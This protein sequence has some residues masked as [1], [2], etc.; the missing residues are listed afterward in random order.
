MKHTLWTVTN[1]RWTEAGIVGEHFNIMAGAYVI[2]HVVMSGKHIS[3]KSAYANARLI[4]AA[5]HLLIALQIF[6]TAFH[7]F[8]RFPQ[9]KGYNLSEQ[10]RKAFKIARAAIAKATGE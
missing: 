3:H 2:A 6:V 4:A 5:P 7:D 8:E 10:S 9:G 1:G